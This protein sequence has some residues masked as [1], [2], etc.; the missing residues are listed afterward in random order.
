MRRLAIG[1]QERCGIL[2]AQAPLFRRT[3][4]LRIAVLHIGLACCAVAA[5]SEAPRAAELTKVG[6][7]RH[8]KSSTQGEI[9]V[10]VR[11]VVTYFD[12]VAPNLFVQDATGGIW[13]DLRG[14]KL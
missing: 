8:L 5:I 7:I 1:Q 11:G 13:V 12:T 9:G 10:H 2:R 3:R 4:K 6:Q 14:S